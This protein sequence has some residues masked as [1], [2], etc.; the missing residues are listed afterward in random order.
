MV[1]EISSY[2]RW[3]LD[4]MIFGLLVDGED[5]AMIYARLQQRL[6][7]L[8]TDDPARPYAFRRDGLSWA[9]SI[10]LPYRHGGMTQVPCATPWCSNLVLSRATDDVQCDTCQHATD[11]AAHTEPP[12][13]TAV[14]LDLINR[15]HSPAPLD[16]PTV[17]TPQ[18]PVEERPVELPATVRE[19]LDVI[20]TV[21]PAAAD[22]ARQAALTLHDLEN[23]TPA[24][25][26]HRDRVSAAMTIY[27][28]ITERHADLLARHYAA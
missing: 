21:D 20:A 3:R 25:D 15:P 6:T 14:L 2:Q 10:G 7:P 27:S 16:E 28:Q 13:P 24:G 1:G 11:R 22:R 23:S 19:Q 8:H 17:P 12:P 18:R 9:L 5:D 4:R 26:A